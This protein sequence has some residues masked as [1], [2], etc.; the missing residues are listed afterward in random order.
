MIRNQQILRTMSPGLCVKHRRKSRYLVLPRNTP[1]DCLELERDNL[2]H[3]DFD[4]S[5]HGPI[6]EFADVAQVRMHGNA[7]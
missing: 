6:S 4:V 2:S 3:F 1:D 5:C 7:L